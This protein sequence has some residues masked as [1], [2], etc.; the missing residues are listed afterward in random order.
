MV[1]ILKSVKDTPTIYYNLTEHSQGPLIDVYPI[2][3]NK[4]H[5]RSTLTR[6]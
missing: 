3:T 2:T 6:F 1:G 4:T 5:S